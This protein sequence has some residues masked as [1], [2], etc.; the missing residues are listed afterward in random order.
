MPSRRTLLAGAG[1]LVGALAGCSALRSPYRT[2][3]DTPTPGSM[4]KIDDWQYDPRDLHGGG[5]AGGSGAGGAAGATA[6]PRAAGGR[7]GSADAAL[8]SEAASDSVGLAA[9][10]AKDANNF[11]ENVEQG[12]LPL[13]TDVSYEGL[14]YD[15]YFDTGASRPCTQ[16]F[17]PAYSTARSPDPLSGES[18]SY[19]TVGLDSGLSRGD[20]ERKT[21][22]LVVVL[23]VSGSM[24]ERFSQYYYDQDSRT[25][26]DGTERT[27]RTKMAIAREAVADMTTHL[28][29]EDRFGMVLFNDRSTV[30]KP[31]RAVGRTDMDAIRGHVREEIE[32]GGGTRFSGGLDDATD[33]LSPYADADQSEYE[34]R[35]VVITDAMPNLGDA[36]EDGLLG[37]VETNAERNVHTTFV[38]VGVDFNSRLVDALTAVR[39]A[40]YYSVHSAEEFQTRL[41]EEFEYMVTPL[42]YD[43]SLELDSDAYDIERVYG[44]TAADAATGELLRVNTLFPSPSREGAAKGGVVLVMLRPTGEG[45][46]ATLTA[47]WTTRT[48]ERRSVERTVQVS[49][50]GEQYDGTGIRKAILLARYADLLKHWTVYERRGDPSDPKAGIE[51]PPEVSDRRLGRWERQS[52]ELAVSSAFQERFETFADHL[53]REMDAVDDSSLQRELSV[54]R[55]LASWRETSGPHPVTPTDE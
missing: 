26:T 9:G 55:T 45:S 33:L 21:L 52:H 17:C 16:L 36:S 47:G 1:S 53:D 34:T 42:V 5:G 29:A 8:A 14:F 32:A 6:A 54:L 24:G 28:R 3:D 10:G 39:G 38:G 46:S 18:E 19:L 44:S 13:P 43:L 23:D 25:A 12:Y 48:G 22:N 35:M 27:S 20:F 4:R 37:R 49:T 7:G 31:L 40:N 15:Y 11:R 51:K 30:A 2:D 50:G 41:A